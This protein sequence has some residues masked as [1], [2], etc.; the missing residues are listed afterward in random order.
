MNLNRSQKDQLETIVN[1]DYSS[2]VIEDYDSYIDPRNEDQKDKLENF[3]ILIL[4]LTIDLK[5]S[6]ED[7]LHEH[8]M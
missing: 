1:T 3:T 7:R 2:W 5:K 8:F 4:S 6:A